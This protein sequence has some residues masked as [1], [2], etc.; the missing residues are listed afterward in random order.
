MMAQFPKYGL[1]MFGQGDFI[2]QDTEV[3]QSVLTTRKNTR[4]TIFLEGNQTHTQYVGTVL[5]SVCLYVCLIPYQKHQ[6]TVV[7][8]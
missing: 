5:S 8:S 3:V 4:L 6:G 2:N 7:N 1:V